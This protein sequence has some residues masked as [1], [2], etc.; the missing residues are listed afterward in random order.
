MLRCVLRNSLSLALQPVSGCS[1]LLCFKLT[2]DPCPWL[3][4]VWVAAVPCCISNLLMM[5]VL[6]SPVCEW[7]QCLA[8]FQTYFSPWLSSL[9]VAAVAHCVSSLL[10]IPIL[11]SSES[12]CLWFLAAL[13]ACWS[14]LFCFFRTWVAACPVVFYVCLW[15]LS[16]AFQ[17]V[18]GFDVSPLFKPADKTYLW[19]FRMWEDVVAF[20]VSCLLMAFVLHFS[21]SEWLWF[22]LMFYADWWVLILAF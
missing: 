20:C 13:Q 8:M 9:W 7:L 15:F 4:R 5:P 22:L 12:E 11:G 19:F 17:E 16:L 18:S 3:S 2:D 14:N 10:I 21:G 1:A 6:G